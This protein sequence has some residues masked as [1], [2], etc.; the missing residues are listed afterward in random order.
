MDATA[1][2]TIIN[3]IV[4]TNAKMA[5]EEHDKLLTLLDAKGFHMLDD[6]TFVFGHRDGTE[7]YIAL[8]SFYHEVMFSDGTQ[9]N[10][11]TEDLIAGLM[12]FN[13]DNE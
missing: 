13:P 6:A 4:E 9:D 12:V 2:S 1:D 3:K 7:V 11:T 10:Q 8:D 5:A